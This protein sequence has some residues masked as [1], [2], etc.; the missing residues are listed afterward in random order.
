M[1]KRRSEQARQLLKKVSK[2]KLGG[3]PT[4][5]AIESLYDKINEIIDNVTREEGHNRSMFQGKP[6]SLRVRKRGDGEYYLE[7]KTSKGWA[8]VQLTINEE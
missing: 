2:L 3:A 6:G 7:V 4:D 5:R 8:N 1:A